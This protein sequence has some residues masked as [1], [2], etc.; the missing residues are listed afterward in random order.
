MRDLRAYTC[1]FPGCAVGI[2]EHREDWF[3]RELETHRRVWNCPSC[4]E[5]NRIYTSA[6]S[7]E[8]HLQKTHT[9]F[10][11]ELDIASVLD[12]CP[13]SV[14]DVP[15]DS[16]CPLCDDHETVRENKHSVLS[17]IA[18]TDVK[19]HLAD[20][21]E[22]LALFAIL[23]T[24]DVDETPGIGK[25]DSGSMSGH[26]EVGSDLDSLS[27]EP[28]DDPAIDWGTERLERNDWNASDDN[29]NLVNDGDLDQIEASAKAEF[30]EE[31]WEEAE[32]LY[33]QLVVKATVLVGAEDP[34]TLLSEYYLA[35][36]YKAQGRW[37]EAQQL[38]SDVLDARV[39][40]LGPRDPDTIASVATLTELY[41]TLGKKD[42]VEVLGKGMVAA[43]EGEF[44]KQHPETLSSMEELAIFYDK[45]ERIEDAIQL[46]EKLLR[47]MT[48]V[49]GK[50]Y[51][52]TLWCMQGLSA[53]Y[54]TIGRYDEAVQ[55]SEEIVRLRKAHFGEDNP[56]TLEAMVNLA[57]SYG[58]KGQHQEALSVSE[59]VL[60]LTTERLGP[61]HSATL[62]AMHRLGTRL[63]LLNRHEE[64]L[65]LRERVFEIQKAK[66]GESHPDT[67]AAMSGVAMTLG[68]VGRRDESQKMRENILELKKSVSDR[69][70]LPKGLESHGTTGTVATPDASVGRNLSATIEPQDFGVTQTVSIE[71]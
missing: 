50:E 22:Q 21:L 47:T 45:I 37:E 30:A 17:V 65:V 27:A 42:E 16:A 10:A 44:G 55:L 66:L 51:P 3:S 68:K 9:S 19:R 13:Q 25:E 15:A 6:S 35:C 20:H 2:F 52:T 57:A 36:T 59:E 4:T 60:Q 23:P 28:N 39:W 56:Y 24:A 14:L 54:R 49:L 33:E 32:K 69:T 34:R 70:E 26:P 11:G 67:L 29:H 38:H 41:I 53:N 31:K 48:Q 64:A 7:L 40:M 12:A 63:I 61:E 46:R 62:T 5:T 8:E 43:T 18:V 58:R 1:T 71:Y